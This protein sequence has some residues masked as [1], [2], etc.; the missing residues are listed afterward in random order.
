MHPMLTNITTDE[1][2][3]A[4]ILNP[5]KRDL[6]GIRY[7]ARR[8]SRIICV[9]VLL[10]LSSIQC[11]DA[12][13]GYVMVPIPSI[14]V[15]NNT[16]QK[17]S[18]GLT[19]TATRMPSSVIEP[20]GGFSFF[21]YNDHFHAHGYPGGIGAWNRVPPTFI[22]KMSGS[23]QNKLD[24]INYTLFKTN[25]PAEG[26]TAYITVDHSGTC[27]ADE[28]LREC[29]GV[30]VS[31]SR[32]NQY[33]H[34]P[35]TFPFGMCSGVPPVG[36]SCSFDSSYASIDL[37]LGGAGDR[38]GSSSISVSCSRPVVYR[39]SVLDHTSDPVGLTVRDVTIEGGPSPY[40]SAGVNAHESLSVTVA[41]STTSEGHFSTQ[42][43][44]RIDIP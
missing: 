29:V 15:I 35:S 3:P 28:G 42:R 38:R 14:R 9:W 43:I 41:A 8:W 20:L 18:V 10:F 31:N 5:I 6:R 36:V 44:L 7:I 25:R 19:Y 16:C 13:G 4:A 30:F 40:I 24:L 27:A 37:G 32:S 17:W 33:T 1:S 26:R 39:V 22:F 34:E 2:E 23:P 21:T 11:C 12:E